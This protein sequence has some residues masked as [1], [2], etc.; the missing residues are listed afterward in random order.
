MTTSQP[1]L[2]DLPKNP[3]QQG[4]G[5][6]NNPGLP[7]Q[8]KVVT[9]PQN[10]LE[11]TQYLLA[12]NPSNTPHSLT[13]H[14]GNLQAT[15]NNT[16]EI[17]VWLATHQL[18]SLKKEGNNNCDT[19]KNLLEQNLTKTIEIL[20][21][22]R[23][24]IKQDLIIIEDIGKKRYDT[25]LANQQRIINIINENTNKNKDEKMISDL[26]KDFD[27][28]HLENKDLQNKLDTLFENSTKRII[29][30]ISEKL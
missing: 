21:Q 4:Y 20:E 5:Y 2:Q 26:Q 27:K 16:T 28:L 14:I 18:S 29:S 17:L 8:G 30:E 11:G 3:I 12:T 6:T 24:N 25:L 9:I 7:I 22:N 23:Q 13:Y 19:L 10:L 15:L 1:N